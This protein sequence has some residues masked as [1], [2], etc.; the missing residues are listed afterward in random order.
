MNKMNR[1][2][3]IAP[4]YDR[5]ARLAFGDAILNSQLAYLNRIPGAARILVLGGGTGVFL[6]K[7]Y[8]CAP[9]A[10]V[11]YVD[12]SQR[13][14]TIARQNKPQGLEVE[15]IHGGLVDIPTETKFDVV[16]TYFFLDMFAAGDL[17]KLIKQI[18]ATVHP[19]GIWLVSDF[20][21]R[22]WWHGTLLFCMYTFFFVFAGVSVFSLPD[23]NYQFLR[24]GMRNTESCRFF[25]GFI[26][27]AIYTREIMFCKSR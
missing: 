20:V 12:A 4:Y 3:R 19:G 11:C 25:S 6:S 8:Q 5:L 1:F 21:K 14:L 9:D 7:L 16:I 15:F 24:A 2:D 27:S 17:E 26:E 18:G 13:M 10:R 22:R 23:W